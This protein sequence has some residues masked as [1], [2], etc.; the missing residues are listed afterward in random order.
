MYRSQLSGV[1]SL[2]SRANSGHLLNPY[3][4]VI[5]NG[6]YYLI[7]ND[8]KHDTLTV[9]RIDRMTDVEIQKEAARPVR[10]LQGYHEGWNLQEFREH[11]AN[12]AFGDPVR[13]TFIA[14]SRAVPIVIDAF[15]KGVEFRERKDGRYD[16]TVR[17]PTFDMKLF[18]MQQAGVIQ[19]TAPE[20]LVKEIREELQK[21]AEKYAE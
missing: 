9:Y 16:C 11:N 13:I 17:V 8:D 5:R 14:E 10:E 15:G 20:D 21:A 7:C 19:V 2:H 3:A 6:F 4:M 18:A 1:F 12:M